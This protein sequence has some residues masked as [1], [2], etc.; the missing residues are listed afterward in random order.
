MSTIAF[1]NIGMHGYINPTLPLVSELVRRGHRVTYHTSPAFADRIEATG[2][3]VLL[4]VGSDLAVPDPPIPLAMMKGLG[5][6]AVALLPGVLAD[7]RAVSPDLVVHGAACPWGCVAARQLGV[8]AAATF[9]TFAFNAHTAS[10]TGL[11][12]QLMKAAVHYPRV[13]MQYLQ[14]RWKLQRSYHADMLPVLD[15]M[16]VRG[17]LNLVFTTPDFQPGGAQFNDSYRF[18]G[19][20]TG[21]RPV[22]VGFDALVHEPPLIYVS[23]G[24]VF[25]AGTSLLHTLAEALSPLA[26]TV[27]LA[28]GQTDPGALGPVAQNVIVRRSVPQLQVLKQAAL[29]VTHGGMNSVNEA[30]AAGVPVLVIPQGADQPMVARRVCDLGAGLALRKEEADAATVQ[31]L[32][33]ELLGDS[34]FKAAAGAQRTSHLLAGG[35]ARAADEIETLLS[36]R[37]PRPA[38]EW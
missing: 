12:W 13:A 29:F 34:R 9:T 21:S 33:R 31:R 24:T 6:T 8:P 10:P 19:A 20:C 14:A 28:A 3:Q 11:S 2:A 30:M 23:L 26:G 1:I 17:E 18:V 36:R 38:E 25:D 4:Y 7:L 15:M 32:A 27:V 5:C 16:N 37:T 35:A 22:D